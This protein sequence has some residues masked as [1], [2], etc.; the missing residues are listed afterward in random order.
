MTEQYLEQLQKQW[1]ELAAQVRYHK[2]LYYN[3]EPVIPDADFDALFMQLQKLEA[4]HPELAAQGSPTQQVGAAISPKDNVGYVQHPS[5]M[6]SLMDVFSLDELEKW[7]G[8][9]PA[10]AYV[11]ELKID[12][13][14]INLIYR[15]GVL[16]QA[17]VR[18]DGRVGED[19]TANAKVI[20]GIPHVLKTALD[21]PI[22]DLLEV[23]GEVFMPTVEFEAINQQLREQGK[24]TF[25]N[26][27]N[28]AA[29][30]VRR[31]NSAEVRKNNLSMICHGFGVREGFN[32]ES[33][34]EAYQA[35]AAWG[36][37]ISEHNS[38]VQTPAEIFERVAYWEKHRHDAIY[39]TDGLVIK[40]DSL[41]EQASYGATSVAPKWAIAYKFLPEEVST[42]LHEIRVGVGR[43]GRVTPVAVMEPVPLAGTTVSQ[44]TL[45][46]P[47]EIKHKKVLI[48]DT[49]VIRKA[50]DI[51]PEVLGPVL[52]KRDGSEREYI[53]PNLCPSCGTEL[54]HIKQADVEL[55][56]PNTRS[57]PA[58]L[59]SRIM[60]ISSRKVFDI[61]E[62]GAARIK[63]LVQHGVLESAADLFD[64]TATDLQRT[65]AFSNTAGKLTESGKRL[66]TQLE[67]A[68]E[69]DLWR[70]IVAL[71]IR[72][73]GPVAARLFAE[74]Y[75]SIAALS[76][77]PV[78]ELAAIDGVAEV[79]AES[80][81][82]WFEVPWHR[83][84][85]E[86][87][88]AAGVQMNLPA[89]ETAVVEIPQVLAGK[90][91]VVTG[92]LENFKR[93]DAKEAV[94][95]RGGKFTSSVTKKT[96]YLVAGADPGSKA[97]K[98]QEL[99]VE[100]LDEQGFMALLEM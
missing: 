52:E 16:S 72:H 74:K 61:Q 20:S 21:F 100:I 94:L 37:P 49:V 22:P 26:P 97:R 9:T 54:R 7:L 84:L 10:K 96:D 45:H 15:N 28:A 47:T 8:V 89:P 31:K 73:V 70:V 14:A 71:S 99:G 23:R 86:R 24:K 57:C 79:I 46:N 29:G 95:S 53:F 32:P 77:A 19:I 50:G 62:L 60:H 1:N 82:N 43:T 88:E 66:L 58:Q 36:F 56:C 3:G 11:T 39:E 90:T 63:D 4:E 17:A 65:K 38:L 64:L 13:V 68:K 12:G 98:A 93:D 48:G 81:V 6:Y 33:Q 51:I 85:V 44:A 41:S 59:V 35:L 2:D 55:R 69:V 5:R 40:V 76:K 34:F 78:A 91:I 67:A 80:V 25:A 30:T 87:W 83:E 75:R 27:R 18:G 42:Q 92:K